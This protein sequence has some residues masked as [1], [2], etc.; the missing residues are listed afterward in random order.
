M[1]K[2]N[3]NSYNNNIILS[4]TISLT[5]SGDDVSLIAANGDVID[6]LVYDLSWYKD[7]S[8]DDGGWSLER[9]NPSAVCEG[10]DNWQASLDE[11][12]GTPGAANSVLADQPDEIMPRIV[13]AFPSDA[14]TLNVVFS[15]AINEML[16]MEIGNYSIDGGIN[17]LQVSPVEPLV[18]SV[19]IYIDP[20]TAL[21]TSTV[22]ELTI[23]TNLKDCVGNAFDANSIIQ[24]ALPDEIE[25]GDVI[26]N[27]VLFDPPTGGSDFIELY[28]N[29]DKIVNIADL[30]IVNDV[31]SSSPNKPVETDYLLFPGSYVVL[32]PNPVDITANYNVPI[33]DALLNNSLPTLSADFGNVTIITEGGVIDR[34][35]YEEDYHFELLDDTK[36]VSLERIDANAETNG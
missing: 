30:V 35:D 23:T 1:M 25:A 26:I 22:Y 13:S 5:N 11:L 6:A 28:N 16:A 8:K 14:T 12:G 27:E 4:S 17:I 32:S 24:F 10:G 18:N 29:S 15:E 19:D 7:G 20:A 33:E 9:I 3:Y 31:A 2:W 34:F 21:Q 36:G